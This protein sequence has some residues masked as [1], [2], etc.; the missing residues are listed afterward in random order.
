MT[1]TADAAGERESIHDSPTR[2]WHVVCAH[3]V[4]LNQLRNVYLGAER[5]GLIHTTTHGSDKLL[6]PL[7][8]RNK[9]HQIQAHN[10]C[11]IVGCPQEL[12]T[13]IKGVGNG[14]A[15]HS[16]LSMLQTTLG[17]DADEMAGVVRGGACVVVQRCKCGGLDFDFFYFFL[18]CLHIVVR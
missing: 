12:I 11:V 4:K 7:H 5:N 2:Q 8:T 13:R 17:L 1:M 18:G 10:P 14:W 3:R 6:T 15:P 9:N 16:T